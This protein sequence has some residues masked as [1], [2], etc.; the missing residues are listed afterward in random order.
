[1]G[2]RAAVAVV[3]RRAVRAA[4]EAAVAVGAEDRAAPA[5]VAVANARP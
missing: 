3:D 2:G 5:V 4:A 1:V